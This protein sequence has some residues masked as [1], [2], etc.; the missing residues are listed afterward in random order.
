MIKAVIF[1]M[2]ETL[3]THYRSALYFGEDI[4]RDLNLPE[5]RFR[6]GWDSTE[7]DRSIGL[8]TFEQII[9]QIMEKN[10]IYSEELL[11]HVSEKRLRAKRELFKH[12]D[13]EIVPMLEQLRER[14]IKLALIS[15]CFSE[16]VVAIKESI[17]Y[18]YFDTVLLS[19]EQG[20]MKPD[21][22]IYDRCMRELEVEP[23]ECLYVGDGGSRELETASEIGMK[24][25]Q[26]TWYFKDN[27]RK[28]LM[29]K[30]QIQQLNS[31]LE[32]L[33]YL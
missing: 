20:V 29:Y 31:P 3:V 2:F 19:Y 24:A 9:R 10:A 23:E 21:K 17:L 25:L 16:E 30:Q 5:E 15:N 8:F 7:E 28:P 11:N 1:D 6:E 13:G 26:A 12:L 4:A 18:P 33:H 27:G 32:V 22:E 14:N